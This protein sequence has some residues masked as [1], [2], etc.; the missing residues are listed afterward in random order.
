MCVSLSLNEGLNRRGSEIRKEWWGSAGV[1]LEILE[2]PED[3]RTDGRARTSPSGWPG[4]EGVPGC[5]IHMGVASH[6]VH[7]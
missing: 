4:T 6:D 5:R 3:G 1:Y 2:K 7:N